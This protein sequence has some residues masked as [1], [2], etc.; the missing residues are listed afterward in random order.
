[1]IQKSKG[2]GIIEFIS[3]KSKKLVY[4]LD[5]TKKVIRYFIHSDDGDSKP[6]D[7]ILFTGFEKLPSGVYSEGFGITTSGW[8]ID[9]YL[10][11]A[12]GD[13]FKFVISSYEASSA[14]KSGNEYTVTFNFK[15]FK[16]LQERLREI[17][18][19]RNKESENATRY[20]LIS[21]FQNIL[22][23][24]TKESLMFMVVDR[25]QVY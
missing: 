11:E 10:R 2:K 22:K 25:L 7:E 17:K 12:F 4:K 9:K 18:A 5:K 20:F 15:E 13:K 8:L 6:Y 23:R 1:M 14:K 19:E 3:T 24:P 21:T 16:K